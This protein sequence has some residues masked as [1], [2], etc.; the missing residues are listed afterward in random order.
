[1]V[2]SR[3]V[4][5]ALMKPPYNFIPVNKEVDARPDLPMR[6]LDDMA[7]LQPA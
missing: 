4:Q 5:E 1:M 6:S 7:P 3:G 2:V